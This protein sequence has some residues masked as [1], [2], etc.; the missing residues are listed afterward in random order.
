MNTDKKNIEKYQEDI[1]IVRENEE[2]AIKSIKGKKIAVA[3]KLLKENIEIGTDSSLTYDMLLYIYGKKNDY[4][5]I[6]KV[7][8]AGIKYAGDKQK[9]RKL[10]KGLVTRKI[11][12]DIEEVIDPEEKE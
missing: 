8:N 9:Y 10:K 5:N 2:K 11:M 4:H 7:L 3:E 6:I 12:D 1:K